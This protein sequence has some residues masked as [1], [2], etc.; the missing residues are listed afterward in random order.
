MDNEKVRLRY[1]GFILFFS[2]LLSVGTGM[3]FSLMVTRSV[4]AENFGVFSNI[5]DVLFYLTLLAGVFPF[6]TTR[7]VARKHPGSSITGLVANVLTSLPCAA[8]YL[9][10]LPLIMASF[11]I[12]MEQ[13][14][15]YVIVT[16]EML[17]IYLLVAFEAVLQARRPQATGFGFLIFELCKV[18]F[19]F[20]FVMQL[21]LEMFG[22]V[23]SIISAYVFQIAYCLKLTLNEFHEKVKWGYIKEWLK[24]SPLNLYGLAGQR[25]AAFYLILLFVYGGE[26]ARG[27]Y[28]A[29]ATVANI[30]GYS[31]LLGYAMYPRLLSEDR[32]EDIVT[33]LRLV[34]MFGI[35]MT[36]GAIVLS[37]SYLTILKA[38]YS[39]AKP[40]LMLLA[41]DV[42]C[43]SLSSIFN[44]VV[45]GTEKLDVEAKISFKK[46]VRS[47]LFLQTSL[48]YLQAA[49]VLP[50]TYVIL[51]FVVKEPVEA[52]VSVASMVL[53][54]DVFMTVLRYSIA[55]KSLRF[56]IPWT[57]ICKYLGA[58]AIMALTLFL[59]PPPSRISTTLAQTL[60]GSAIYFL[61]LSAID[62]EIRL[63]IKS[64][65]KELLKIRRTSQTES[66]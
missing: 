15:I 33:S 26:L 7:F 27:Y 30:I 32:P 44:A 3:I 35:P 45:A 65:R 19:G 1:S 37:G 42:L 2:R 40:A 61:V 9:A 24:A 11:Q 55:R 14:A 8:I 23:V 48:S 41:V 17:E 59:L 54:V 39:V 47:R 51:N 10:I 4:S 62:K 50:A 56:T 36:A 46:I 18:F 49:V 13:F 66:T 60:L 64:A 58:S 38:F 57:S 22:A 31:S 25:I 43:V 6:W 52:V 16:L 12:G 28:A 34:L 63:I 20:V 29:A 5:G 53:V 21:R